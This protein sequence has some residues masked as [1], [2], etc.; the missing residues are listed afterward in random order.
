MKGIKSALKILVLRVGRDERQAEARPRREEQN[1][2]RAEQNKRKKR[3]QRQENP[4][5]LRAM[6]L[7]ETRAGT[8]WGACSS[9]GQLSARGYDY[10]AH[11]ERRPSSAS[12]AAHW[13][14]S[15]ARLHNARVN[16]NVTR[17][18]ESVRRISVPRNTR[19]L[20]SLYIRTL[21]NKF[22][23]IFTNT[24]TCIVFY[25]ILYNAY[26]YCSV[27]SWGPPRV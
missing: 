19:R 23:H 22:M 24:H 2:A 26:K 14:D 4:A 9:N 7:C 12:N 21:L 15:R 3:R 13:S 25:S 5:E 6:N 17:S 8:R 1:R 11:S 18:T 10:H 27:Q 20:H 16:N